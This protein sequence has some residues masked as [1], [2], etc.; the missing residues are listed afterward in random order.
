MKKGVGFEEGGEVEGCRD[1]GGGG[2]LFKY[3]EDYLLDYL[4]DYWKNLDQVDDSTKG[5]ISFNGSE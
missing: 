3:I 4:E 2:E 1:K 5:L